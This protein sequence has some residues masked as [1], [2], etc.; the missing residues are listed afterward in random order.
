[1]RRSI[2]DIDIQSA[3]GGHTMHLCREVAPDAAGAMLR[4]LSTCRDRDPGYDP[5]DLRVVWCCYHDHPGI[6]G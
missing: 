4:F 5:N 6:P 1:M 3:N 2:F